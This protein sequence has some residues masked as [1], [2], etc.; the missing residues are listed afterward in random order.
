VTGAGATAVVDGRLVL[1]LL[2]FCGYG[3]DADVVDAEGGCVDDGGDT[4]IEG[5]C[6]CCDDNAIC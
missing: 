3:D 2:R 5:G 1:L 6:C 4:I